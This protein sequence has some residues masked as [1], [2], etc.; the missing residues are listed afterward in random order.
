[1]SKVTNSYGVEIFFNAAVNLMDDDIRE[2]LHAE[3]ID[4][5]QAFFDAY[6]AAHEQKF[7][8][9]WELDKPNPIY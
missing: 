3:G 1:M 2:H 9:P 4:D 5:E 6:A 7:G 8:E